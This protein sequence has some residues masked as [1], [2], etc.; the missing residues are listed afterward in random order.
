[1]DLSDIINNLNPE[2][3][4]KLRET[5]KSVFGNDAPEA[6]TMKKEPEPFPA[7]L[8]D[9]KTMEKIIKLSSMMTENDD[10]TKFL[11]ALKPLL[12]EKRRGKADTAIQMQRLLRVIRALNG[13]ENGGPSASPDS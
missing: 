2:D 1:M 13:E 5:A 7:F 12:S 3:I 9:P 10:K 6:A 8:S 11:L 4:E